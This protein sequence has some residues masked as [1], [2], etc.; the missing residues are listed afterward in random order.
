MDGITLW[1]GQKHLV[2]KYRDAEEAV[3]ERNVVA[4]SILQG[5]P[6]FYLIAHCLDRNDQRHFRIDRIISDVLDKETGELAS[7][8]DICPHE[9]EPYHEQNDPAPKDGGRTQ[10]KTRSARPVQRKRSGKK[11]PYGLP[12]VSGTA[13]IQV[14]DV[15]DYR[16]FFANYFEPRERKSVSTQAAL[17]LLDV[18][19]IE[20]EVDGYLEFVERS[21]E[22]EPFPNGISV[23]EVVS[24]D[25]EAAVRALVRLD[26]PCLKSNFF[27][28]DGPPTADDLLGLSAARL[29]ELARDQELK[30]S[31]TKREL[32]SA[33]IASGSNLGLAV[34]R[35]NREI[36][37]QTHRRLS[38]AY[39]SNIVEIAK[40]LPPVYQEALWRLTSDESD[41]EESALSHAKALAKR[42]EQRA[43]QEKPLYRTSN[44]EP[45][46]SDTGEPKKS[47][48]NSDLSPAQIF[49]LVVVGFL[50]IGLLAL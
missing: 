39:L 25:T 26:H 7:L 35:L 47:M 32:S 1:R 49:W 23:Y 12:A 38:L 48:L 17:E 40:G 43:Q 30:T 2:F 28:D 14:E 41:L 21:L 13:M 9:P 31:Q 6:N 45:T 29:K 18:D 42:S 4:H 24:G 33:L 34:C 44:S 5:G 37:D 36:A 46:K 3:T 8:R 27:I 50:A 11:P 16:D 20:L 15:T 22:K 19:D 10:F